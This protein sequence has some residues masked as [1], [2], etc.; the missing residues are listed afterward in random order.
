MQF[1]YL[2]ETR[3]EKA[4]PQW[5]FSSSALAGPEYWHCHSLQPA[6]FLLDPVIDVGRSCTADAN[7]LLT[8][9]Y[10]ELSLLHAH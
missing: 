5:T 1:Q 3:T 4:S 10:S 2:Y 9:A 6:L 7:R 8:A